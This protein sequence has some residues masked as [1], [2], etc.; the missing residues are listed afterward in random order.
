MWFLTG[1]HQL[2]AGLEIA[3]SQAVI[4]ASVDSQLMQNSRME[5]LNKPSTFAHGLWLRAKGGQLLITRC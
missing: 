1:A 2:R 5:G 3:E 4:F